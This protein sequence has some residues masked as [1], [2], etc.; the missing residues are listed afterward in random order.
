M[1]TEAT[2]QRHVRKIDFAQAWVVCEACD[3]TH[4]GREGVF[5]L[6]GEGWS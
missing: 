4:F 2:W 6:C 1:I 3:T 5:A